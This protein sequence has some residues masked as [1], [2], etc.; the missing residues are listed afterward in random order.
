MIAESL[1]FHAVMD[2][3]AFLETAK[4]R[5]RVFDRRLADVGLLETAFER[6]VLLD[7]L[8]VFV[9]RRGADAAQITA[10]QRG[11]QHVGCVHRAFGAAGADQRVK[12][13]DEENDFAA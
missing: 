13:V 1:I 3:V 10:R 5:D 12:F 7:V 2:L 11:F 4:N 9:E 8:L 6:L